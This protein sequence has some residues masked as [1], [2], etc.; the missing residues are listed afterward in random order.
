MSLSLM[1]LIVV[2][3]LCLWLNLL[4]LL[5]VTLRVL[6]YILFLLLIILLRSIRARRDLVRTIRIGRARVSDA[7]VR[8]SFVRS[9]KA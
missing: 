1:R 2:L 8:A 9:R 7:A 3:C 5:R 6:V 4:S